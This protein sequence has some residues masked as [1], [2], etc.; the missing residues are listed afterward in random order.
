MR[1]FDVDAQ[2]LVLAVD[3]LE[4]GVE[5]LVDLGQRDAVLRTLGTGEARYDLRQVELE[6]LGED[7]LGLGGEPHALFFGI[8]FDQRDGFFVAAG[9]AH[10]FERFVVDAEE[11]A[12]CAVFGGHVGDG[13]T[14]GE[15]QPRNAF[16]VEFDEPADHADFAQHLHAGQHEVGGGHTFGHRAGQL[17]SDHFG[18]QHRNRLA[19]HCGFGLDPADTPAKHAE[20]V[21][22]GGMAVGAHAGVGIGNRFAFGVIG[23]PHALADIFQVHLVAD[24][25]A[26][27]HGGEVLEALR[28]PLEEVVTLRIAG[29]FEFDVL[30]ESL[31]VAEFIN[32]HRVVDD[33]VHGNL[34]VNLG[35]IAAELADRIAHG[36]KVDHAGHAGEILQEHARRAVLDFLARGRV[37]LPVDDRLG[38]VGADG[39]TTVFETQHVLQ[40]HLEAERQL[41]N[42]A[43]LFR[44]LG[45]G[46]IGVVLAVHCQS[47]A[48]SERVLADLG[49]ARVDPFVCKPLPD[50][51]AGQQ[52]VPRPCA[53][54]GKKSSVRHCGKRRSAARASPAAT[55]SCIRASLHAWRFDRSFRSYRA[56]GPGACRAPPASTRRR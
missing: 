42:I 4:V 26:R 11:A 40:Q 1:V 9:E 49:H 46:V 34:R 22:H 14:V 39:E 48:G 45:E 2:R 37:L 24:A 29:I 27:R 53:G 52:N 50:Q 23:R 55:V 28:T 33:E 19:E 44:R 13:R 17:E 43:Q 56:A 31:G 8:G 38:I 5:Q 32:H 25:G 16:A 20:A 7:G 47:G 6:R 3:R 10:V 41:R 18:D 51:W 35:G 21:D 54:T 12:G 30:L 36:S 15:G